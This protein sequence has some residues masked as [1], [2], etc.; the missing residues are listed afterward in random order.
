MTKTTAAKAAAPARDPDEQVTIR[1]TGEIKLEEYG[2]SAVYMPGTE[3]TVSAKMLKD[4]RLV[5]KF[6][7]V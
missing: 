4:K 7:E 6:E 5:G 3:M 1:L 2:P